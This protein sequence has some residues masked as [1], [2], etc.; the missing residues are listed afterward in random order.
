MKSQILTLSCVLVAL[1][2][3]A[4]PQAGEVLTAG[5]DGTGFTIPHFVRHANADSRLSAQSV[6]DLVPAQAPAAKAPLRLADYGSELYGYVNYSTNSTETPV[7]LYEFQGTALE[8]MWKDEFFAQRALSLMCGFYKD[9]RL[10]GYQ[11][12]EFNGQLLA[13]IYSEFDFSTGEMKVSDELEPVTGYFMACTYDPDTKTIYGYG[14]S[15][16]G[17]CFASAPVDDP[18]DFKVIRKINDQ[19]NYSDMC[20]AMTYNEADDTLYGVNFKMELVTIA[21]DGTTTKVMDIEN[22]GQPGYISDMAWSQKAGG[23]FVNYTNDAI[24][25]LYLLDP[26]KKTSRLI[27]SF[28]NDAAF[29]VMVC[30]DPAGEPG[31]A[32]P[33][34]L[35]SFDFAPGATSGSITFTLPTKTLGGTALPSNLKW[36]STIDDKAHTNGSAQ[37]GADITVNYSGLSDDMH[38]FGLYIMDNGVEGVSARVR[39]YVGNDIPLAPENVVLTRDK[40]TWDPVTEGV[41]EAYL[42]LSK[43]EY[44]VFVN[45]KSVG[46]TSSTQIA[47]GIDL[48]GGIAAYTAEVKAICNGMT[49]EAGTSNKV[50]VGKALQLPVS[51]EPNNEESQLFTIVDANGDKATWRYVP[52]TAQVQAYFNSNYSAAD[53]V[54]MDDWLIMPGV[55]LNSTSEYYAFQMEVGRLNSA[56]PGEYYEI[57]AGTEPIPG[58]MTVKIKDKTKV[59][60]AYEIIKEY[61]KVP[62]AGTWFIGIHAVSDADQY[63]FAARDFH[64]TAPGVTDASPAAPTD[65]Q[66][67]AAPDGE[68]KA[69]VTFRFPSKTMTGS[70]LPASAQLSA[71]VEGESSV[72]VT[73]KPGQQTFA[74][75]LTKQGDNRITI[76]PY[77]NDL[78][79]QEGSIILY[80]GVDYPGRVSDLKYEISEDMGSATLTWIPPHIGESGGYIVPENVGFEIRLYNEQEGWVLVDDIGTGKTSYTYTAPAGLQNVY[81]LGVLAYNEA[82]LN[83]TLTQV[84]IMLGDPY[85]LPIFEDFNEGD[86]EPFAIAPWLFYGPDSSYDGQVWDFKRLGDIIPALKDDDNVVLLGGYLGGGPGKGGLQMPCFTT[87]GEPEAYVSC[88]AFTGGNGVIPYLLCNGYGIQEDIRI[89][90]EKITD[91]KNFPTVRYTLPKELCDLG[92]VSAIFVVEFG[93]NQACILDDIHAYGKESGSELIPATRKNISAGCGT[94]TVSGFEGEAVSVYDAAGTRVAHADK[95]SARMLISSEPGV[96]IVRAGDTVRKVMVK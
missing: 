79:G 53:N 74:T 9:D 24:S 68:L 36:Y 93:A 82:G 66:A 63:G 15:K 77:L 62:Q 26:V 78:P 87:K 57:W 46:R 31:Q 95:A 84:S 16:N 92:W 6:T 39:R 30:L 14:G 40:V 20:W 12:M 86:G 49:S 27:D 18:N 71:V 60:S 32:A 88:T 52:A 47:S 76:T 21:T 54:K 22:M 10:C 48:N 45:G 5:S 83:R 19:T 55:A 13:Y 94:I 51:L 59:S 56:Y 96:R 17:I 7:G 29:A 28:D 70:V 80:S 73:G 65:I 67:Q 58:N 1:T 61:F 69:S 64:V 81:R 33:P 91:D 8:L 72:T 43:M 41:H 44:E 42:D 89:E 35:K 23:F 38:V 25:S 3:T 75:V 37:S 2:A 4:A 90:G 50:V 11:T 85:K 34:T